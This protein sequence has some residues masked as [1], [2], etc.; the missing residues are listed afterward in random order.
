[1]LLS[2]VLQGFFAAAV[3]NAHTHALLEVQQDLDRER[4]SNQARRDFLK[5]LFHEVRTP[6]NSLTMGIEL[7]KAK[8]E[9]LDQEDR[10]VLTMMKGSS[11]FMAETLN[12][13]LSIQKIEEGKLE[14]TSAPFSIGDSIS[15]IFLAFSGGI[16]AKSLRVEK[17]ISPGVPALL[18]GDAYRVEHVI[19]NLLSNAIK[20]SP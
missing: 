2:L 20:F 17:V 3:A 19:S 13:V 1:M 4:L 11:D 14:L 12:D 5:Y 15:K 10:D 9:G 16:A 6:L 8:K 18:L 7:L